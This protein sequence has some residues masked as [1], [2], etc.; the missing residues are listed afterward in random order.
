[1]KPTK[2]MQWC[3]KDIAEGKYSREPNQLDKTP[4]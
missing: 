2:E 3:M 1:M 4:D